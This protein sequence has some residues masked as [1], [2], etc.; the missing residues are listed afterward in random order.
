MNAQQSWYEELHDD[1]TVVPVDKY[2]HGEKN[3]DLD[4]LCPLCGDGVVD[5]MDGISDK[6]GCCRYCGRLIFRRRYA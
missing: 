4:D 6:F 3:I 1:D 5:M 2:M